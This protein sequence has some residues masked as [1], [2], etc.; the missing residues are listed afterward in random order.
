MDSKDESISRGTYANFFRTLP[1]RHQP[2][3]YLEVTLDSCFNLIQKV[4]VGVRDSRPPRASC[5]PGLQQ[6]RR[7]RLQ[8]PLGHVQ[9]HARPRRGLRTDRG[10]FFVCLSS[11]WLFHAGGCWRTLVLA[12]L[13]G[14]SS[15]CERDVQQ[16]PQQVS[17]SSEEG[18][19]SHI[20]DQHDCG[21]LTA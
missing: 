11:T 21:V 16:E 17:Q 1:G 3:L 15:V 20:T 19:L 4:C 7:S 10:S 2:S 9:I 12:D 5:L 8:Q 6:Q 13:P 14:P 18:R